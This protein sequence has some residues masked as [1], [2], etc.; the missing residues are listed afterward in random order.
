MIKLVCIKEGH[1]LLVVGNIYDATD[2]GSYYLI[3]T[4]DNSGHIGYK[5]YFIT[6]LQY[7][8]DKK[9]RDLGYE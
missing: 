9:L 6:L 1:Q 7:E 5:D 3:H 4:S 2:E 8:R